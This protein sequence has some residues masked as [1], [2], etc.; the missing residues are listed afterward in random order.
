MCIL[1]SVLLWYFSPAGDEIIFN[2]LAFS[3]ENLLQGKVW[4][5]IT[6]LFIH[7]DVLHLGGNM[8]VL[9]IF[10]NTLEDELGR[11]RV[12]TAFFIGGITSFLLSS[13]FYSSETFLLGASGAIFTLTALV[14]LV[15][16]LR[17]SFFFFM[18]QGLVALIYF[19]YNVA[20]VYFKVQSDVAYVAH[21]IGFL[22][23]IPL[24]I[25]WSKEWIKNFLITIGLLI[26]YYII[27]YIFVIF[28][29]Q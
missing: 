23:G 26:L 18:P 25:G 16:P 10:G 17:F 6:A 21:V 7:S 3:T 20:A 5:L 4:T 28:L 12:A 13:Y 19:V 8:F 27:Q 14:M 24:G 2:Y 9:F 29:I 11:N 15:K 1:T 22:V